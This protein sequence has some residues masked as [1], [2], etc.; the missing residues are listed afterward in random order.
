MLTRFIFQRRG[1]C[2]I[3][4]YRTRD[5]GNCGHFSISLHSTCRASIWENLGGFNGYLG[6]CTKS[7]TSSTYEKF[8]EARCSTCR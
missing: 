6:R 7:L 1:A 3:A 2:V 5:W 8:K 4:T